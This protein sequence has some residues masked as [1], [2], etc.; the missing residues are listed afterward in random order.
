M[1]DDSIVRTNLL[2]ST[3]LSDAL[4]SSPTNID[5][6]IYL[7]TLRII[8]EAGQFVDEISARYFHGIHSFIPIVSRSRFHE[9]LVNFGTPPPA[10]FSTL[11]LAMCLITHYPEGYSQNT[12]SIDQSSL[13]M[14][15]KTMFTQVQSSS[16]PTLHLI[17]TGIIIA[18]YEYANSKIDNALATI[19]I[20][21]RMGYT[22]RIHLSD[23]SQK[24]EDD[25][26]LQAEEEANTWWGIVICERYDI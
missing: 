26:Y 11:L 9:T 16:P 4:L 23:P 3:T 24:L 5:S 17:Q 12:S 10:A 15:A 22:A 14:A 20:C 6:A 19:A 13:Y 7:Q 8:R 2:L 21:A 18:T 1:T 25:G